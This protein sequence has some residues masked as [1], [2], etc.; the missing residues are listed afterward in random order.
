MDRGIYAAASSGLAQIRKLEVVSNNLAN[1]NTPGFKK[2]IITGDVQ[3]FDQT[4]ARITASGDPY[5]Q[6]DHERTPA[7]VQIR[8]ATDFSPGPVKNTGNTLDVALRNPKDFFVIETPAGEQ[9]TRAGNFTLSQEGEIVTQDGFAVQGDGGAITVAGGGVSISPDGSVLVNG[10]AVARLRVMRVEEPAQLE[11]AGAARFSV[12]PGMEAPV[13]VEGDL[14]PQALEMS[15]VSA[16]S[17]VIDLISAQRAFQ[18]YARTTET[19]D[20]MNQTAINQVG[21]PRM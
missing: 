6:P 16:I 8:A 18:M 5:A 15:N 10:A 12:R 19:M 3:T 1:V 2:Q 7:V 20:M 4:L 9:L 21:K 17:S 13:D 11:R 14:I